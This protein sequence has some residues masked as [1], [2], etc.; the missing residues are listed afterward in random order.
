MTT[1]LEVAR[2]AGVSKA[3][4]SRVLSGNGYVSQE[5]KDRVFLAIE[6]SGYRPNLLA[7]NLATKKTQTLGLVVT[8][9][10]YHGVYF[11]ELLFHAASMTEAQGRRLILADGKHSAEEEREAIQ[12][13]LDLR[14][15]GII[16]YPRFLSVDEIDDIIQQQQRPVLVINR[17]LRRNSSH[18]VYCDQKS[19]SQQ[20]VE[21]LIAHGHR[22][23]AFITGSL[24]SPTGIE[25]LS[26]YK[27]ALTKHGITLRN[28]LIVEG[29]WTPATGAAGVDT[30][31]E[32]QASFS[33]L[34]AS[35]D[36]MAVGAIKR[37][38]DHGI[39]VPLQVSVIGFDDI[40]L[41][42][43]MIPSLSS[44]RIPVTEMIKETINRLIFMLD[45]GDFKYQQTFPGELIERDSI[46][47]GPH[48]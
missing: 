35:N 37:L 45:G 31:R 41:A 42:P 48:A 13:L 20:A 23:I 6:E 21:K 9:T 36:D 10:L 11:S 19:A 40:A 2:R 26:G 30:L 8:N 34:V 38:H 33:A 18:C 5:T 24:D 16:I 39:N 12:Y 43:Y 46:V 7:R 32:R 3:T 1:M 15:D 29:K 25:R 27:D 22:D 17:R 44:V 4:V 47:A 14:C 28:E